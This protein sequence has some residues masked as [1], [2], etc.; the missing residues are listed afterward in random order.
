M[1]QNFG[2]VKNALK[3]LKESGIIETVY[4]SFVHGELA[5]Q[6]FLLHHAAVFLYFQ[7][8]AFAAEGA[9]DG[10]VAK[11][12]QMVINRGNAQAA[13]RGE[14]HGAMEGTNLQQEAGKQTKVIQHTQKPH[15]ELQENAGDHQKGVGGLVEVRVQRCILYFFYCFV[16]LIIDVCSG[17]IGRE[18]DLNN[19]LG[20]VR[21]HFFFD[22]HAELQVVATG[23]NLLTAD[24]AVD[25]G[26]FAGGTAV[27]GKQNVGQTEARQ[28]FPTLL[29]NVT[30]HIGDLE[31]LG[32]QIV[33]IVTV[34]HDVGGYLIHRG[35]G[36]DA[37]AIRTVTPGGVVLPKGMALD[38][39]A[40]KEQTQG[41]QTV[42]QCG[43]IVAQTGKRRFT[44]KEGGFSAVQ[45]VQPVQIRKSTDGNQENNRQKPGKTG[46]FGND[47]GVQECVEDHHNGIEHRDHCIVIPEI[48]GRKY[49]EEI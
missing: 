26:V 14:E 2:T 9:K 25:L 42:S 38:G 11:V 45:K 16:H 1:I 35:L 15:S 37:A 49:K 4:N 27:A 46:L 6:I 21:G 22:S 7:R 47:L 5:V 32:E 29:T 20:G 12:V 34:G 40:G 23:V 17:I 18:V 41:H 19:R 33:G 30:L 8:P 10:K 48:N 39:E 24:K 28:S 36:A 3:V 43:L 44:H 13:H 31:G